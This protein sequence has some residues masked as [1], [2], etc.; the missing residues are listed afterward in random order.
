MR[1]IEVRVVSPEAADHGVAEFWLGDALFAET[2][3]QEGE[4]VLRIEPNHDGG[5]VSVN[6]HSLYDALTEAKRLLESF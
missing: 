6:A 5:P 2:Q 4:L 1:H 3:L